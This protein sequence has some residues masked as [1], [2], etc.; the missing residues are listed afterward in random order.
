MCHNYWVSALEPLS[1]GDWVHAA[2]ACAPPQGP[3]SKWDAYMPQL[4]SRRVL[5]SRRKPLCATK[6]TAAEN[7]IKRVFKKG[8]MS[9]MAWSGCWEKKKKIVR[10]IFPLLISV[11]LWVGFTLKLTP[12]GHLAVADRSVVPFYKFSS[13]QRKPSFPQC[14]LHCG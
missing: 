14:H 13:L 8:R 2:G 12:S 7:K 9:G 3:P 1:C 6:P 11:F 4:E 10:N 5:F